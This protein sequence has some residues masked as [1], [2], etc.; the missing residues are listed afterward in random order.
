[1]EPTQTPPRRAYT[2]H[3]RVPT[4]PVDP[5]DTAPQRVRPLANE[6]EEDALA[7]ELSA[8]LD[9]ASRPPMR[10][11]M[12]A[13]SPRDR[14][15]RRAAEIRGH[16]GGENDGTDEFFIPSDMIPDGWSYE[17]KRETVMGQEDP[18]YQVALARQGWEP[19]PASRHP[20]MMPKDWNQEAI[21][22]KGLILCE[23][24]QEISHAARM[25]E[26]RQARQQLQIKKQQLN[27]APAGTFERSDPRVRANVKTSYE[28]MP[29]PADE[30]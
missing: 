13:E 20:E 8:N 10:A 25:K 14:A 4:T 15:A 17:W 16:L 24:P 30:G 6:A 27:E 18:A 19:V 26:Q 12:R 28:P 22:R 7:N 29:I 5:V 2:R 21:K 3:P 11:A 1:M 9:S 23:R